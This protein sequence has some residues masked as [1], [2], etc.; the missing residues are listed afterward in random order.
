MSRKYRNSNEVPTEALCKR[1]DQIIT[2]GDSGKS[3]LRECT[4][5]IPAELD[6]DAD[7]VLAEA[8]RR[9]RV[10]GV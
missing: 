6:K 5:R 3:L 7:L 1:I 8:A 4:M 9:L 2:A 10:L